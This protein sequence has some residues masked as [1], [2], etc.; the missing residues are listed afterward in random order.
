M[1]SVCSV[2][3]LL[4][5]EDFHGASNT[6]HECDVPSYSKCPMGYLYCYSQ[7]FLLSPHLWLNYFPHLATIAELQS[8]EVRPY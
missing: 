6:F 1:D 5:L 4:V 7:Q 2:P 3:F 8:R